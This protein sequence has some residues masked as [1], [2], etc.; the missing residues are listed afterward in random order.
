VNSYL[1][2]VHRAA[3]TD[4]P[5]HY[6]GLLE[7]IH[8]HLLPRTYLEIG[9]AGGASF[10]VVQPWTARVG[11]DPE[12]KVALPPDSG[13]QLFATTSD[14]FFRHYDLRQVLGGRE[15]DMVFIDGMHLFEY[16]LR[17][18][19]NVERFCHR[20]SL[21]LFHDCYPMDETT[22]GRQPTSGGWS[23]DVWKLIVALREYRPDLRIATIDVAPTGLGVVSGVDPLSTILREQYEEIVDRFMGSPYSTISDNKAERLNRVPDDWAAVRALLPPPFQT[24]RVAR[25]LR[26][27][28]ALERA[29]RELRG[30]VSSSPVGPFARSVRE[31]MFA[32]S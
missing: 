13:T 19:L 20:E 7:R 4:E 29:C 18:L 27:R 26:R 25:P 10:S 16:A 15:V 14:D 23:G 32:A 28:I 30:R 12:P 5:R 31:A 8:R 11:V 21:I 9:V 6:I 22:S 1:D 17:D 24:G 2:V 3:L